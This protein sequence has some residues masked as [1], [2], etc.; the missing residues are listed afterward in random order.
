MVELTS[1]DTLHAFT[2]ETDEPET[3]GMDGPRR[4]LEL[5]PG[6]LV[7]GTRYRV[8]GW[9]GS[10][11]MGVVY[12]ARDEDLKRLVALKVLDRQTSRDI[13]AVDMFRQEA[14]VIS[15]LR[16][17][18]IVEVYELMT[19]EDGRLA[20]AMELLEGR[21]LSDVVTGPLPVS[22]VIGILRQICESLR[23]AH[24]AGVVHRDIKP[25]NIFVVNARRPD[26]T[27]LLDFGIASSVVESVDMISGTPGY[28][29]PEQAH[30][31]LS[32]PRTDIYA[33]GV[34]AYEMLTGRR[35]TVGSSHRVDGP[36]LRLVLD[37]DDPLIP[38]P[39]ATILNRCLCESME[40]RYASVDELEAA[41]CE[42]QIELGLTTAWDHLPI[43]D[44]DPE[45]R[46]RVAAAM[47]D[48]RFDFFVRRV[49]AFQRRILAG[50]AALAFALGVLLWPTVEP[51]DV[52]ERLTREADDAAASAHYVYG[53]PADPGGVTAY[54]KVLELEDL[55]SEMSLERSHSLRGKYGTA[56]TLLGDRLWD[57]D[58]GRPFAIDFYLQAR[59]FVPDDERAR[60]RSTVTPGAWES[61][62][63]RAVEGFDPQDLLA[64]EPLRV[65]ARTGPD[66]QALKDL[67]DSDN[68][69]GTT[70]QQLIRLV[71]DPA[72]GSPSATSEAGSAPASPELKAKT[73][74]G[75]D[76][77]AAGPKARSRARTPG[78]GRKG[79]AKADS[80]RSAP[81]GGPLDSGSREPTSAERA[82]AKVLA[83]QAGK[84]AAALDFRGAKTL[85]HRAL[86]LNPRSVP[87]LIGL[88]EVH[89]E[90]DQASRSVD[91]G[92]KAARLAPRNSRVRILL[93]DAYFRLHRY[94]QAR[95]EYIAAKKL[96]HRKAGGRLEKLRRLLG[97]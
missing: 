62:K 85:Y 44:I 3:Q 36:H 16:S 8:T 11:G 43:P 86:A 82:E 89:F 35:P 26:T 58:G 55:D 77:T 59:I 21:A 56:L 68:L 53:S 48:P 97:Q 41:L 72:A 24:A 19:L 90:L 27:K 71:G 80:S 92:K 6:G 54:R 20:Y 9:L 64:A 13:Q 75:S 42:A 32:D 87:A 10:G 94:D 18:H 73:G 1:P 28:M 22:R 65:L 12:Q 81:A 91:L 95:R 88:A 31:T 52:I 78:R 50:V 96:G 76:A 37:T 63:A 51:V 17:D 40:D 38:G 45:R 34:V 57:R 93:G 83:R 29:A 84:V 67:V 46:A 33:V 25:R 74:S 7:P 79:K 23:V 69:A 14:Q 4:T 39:L 49:R 15:S 60:L 70:R 5:Q 66:S 30:G 61:F 47:P 2:S